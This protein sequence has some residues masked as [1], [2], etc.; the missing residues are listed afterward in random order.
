MALS[1]HTGAHL[2]TT[3]QLADLQYQSLVY[4]H[5]MSIGQPTYASAWR[6]H[7]LLVLN[8]TTTV[9]KNTTANGTLNLTIADYVEAI[10]YQISGSTLT[11]STLHKN[12]CQVSCLG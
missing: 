6:Y 2:C 9:I 3:D 12:T 5:L 7:T 4:I 1:M 8:G 10:Y 11:M